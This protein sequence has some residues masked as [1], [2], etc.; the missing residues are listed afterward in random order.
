MAS[1]L[2]L[3]KDFA[4][5]EIRSRSNLL[6]RKVMIICRFIYS[7]NKILQVNVTWSIALNIY[8]VNDSGVRFLSG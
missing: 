7:P 1:L 4:N 6:T 2:D 8:C 5:L 3:C